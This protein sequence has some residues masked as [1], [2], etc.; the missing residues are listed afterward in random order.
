MPDISQ[1]LEHLL[2]NHN[3]VIIPGFGGF[4]GEYHSAEV[5]PALHRFHPPFKK[6]LFNKNLVSNDGLLISRIS[7]SENISY[8]K[9][10]QQLTDFVNELN[11][12]LM[13]KETVI[14]NGIGKFFHDMENNLQFIADSE[15]NL[16]LSS[17][18]LKSVKFSPILRSA[19][20]E[21]LQIIKKEKKEIITPKIEVA[22]IE[23]EEKPKKIIPERRTNFFDWSLAAVVLIMVGISSLVMFDVHDSRLNEFSSGFYKTFSSLFGTNKDAP[24]IE[25][26]IPEVN[27]PKP[28]YTPKPIEHR[29]NKDEVGVEPLNETV[30]SAP[31]TPEVKTEKV[32]VAPAKLETENSSSQQGYYIIL[33]AFR[34]EENA[35][36]LISDLQNEFPQIMIIT[37]LSGSLKKVGF[38]A[39]EE[40]VEAQKILTSTKESHPKSWMTKIKP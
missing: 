32:E 33:G 35:T 8:D 16:L 21:P 31:E 25:I 1:H 26:K 10:V 38:F 27:E 4:V 20:T 2:F 14:V 18:G 23:Q 40:K 34:E 36:N 11:M 28:I 29:N 39:S 13:S 7:Q 15:N 30:E 6:I 37:Q 9:A 19:V 5:H 24:A 17:F 3:C 12:R 22:L